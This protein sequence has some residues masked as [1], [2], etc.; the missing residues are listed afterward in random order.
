MEKALKL[1][2]EVI[3][4]ER[5][6]LDTVWAR[7]DSRGIK[8]VLVVSSAHSRRDTVDCTVLV[9]GATEGEFS[10]SLKKTTVFGCGV[11]GSWWYFTVWCCLGGCICYPLPTVMTFKRSLGVLVQQ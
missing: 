3:N 2:I 8:Y 10:F 11:Y 4:I 5:I 6:R 9:N 7:A 1:P